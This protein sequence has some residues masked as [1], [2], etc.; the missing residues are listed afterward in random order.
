MVSLPPVSHQTDLPVHAELQNAAHM[1]GQQ[2]ML[3]GRP[4]QPGRGSDSGAGCLSN[5]GAAGDKECRGTD[6]IG[7]RCSS[8]SQ[9]NPAAELL[10][11]WPAA[12]ALPCLQKRCQVTPGH[13][14]SPGR[15]GRLSSATCCCHL[16]F[17]GCLL[18]APAAA[19]TD[20]P[21]SG[22]GSTARPGDAAD[23]RVDDLTQHTA[24]PPAAA[25]AAA[26]AERQQ[27]QQPGRGRRTSH[28]AAG[29]GLLQASNPR[30]SGRWRPVLLLLLPV[31]GRHTY[32]L[33]T[34]ASR[35]SQS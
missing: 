35:C 11:G 1:Y 27:R 16:L 34:H 4:G 7:C 6:A 19:T 15:R 28:I 25:A 2:C 24:P 23:G 20:R 21:A 12:S 26:A 14:R 5:T 22:N 17:T 33:S 10:V 13:A 29:A 32:A 30:D 9:I 8:R 3:H 18:P 31:V